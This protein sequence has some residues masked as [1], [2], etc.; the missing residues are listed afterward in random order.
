MKV[1]KTEDLNW[2]LMGQYNVVS[3]MQ[4]NFRLVGRFFQSTGPAETEVPRLDLHF[5][6]SCEAF[7]Q[8]QGGD[9]EVSPG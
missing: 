7:S 5:S 2:R 8:P 3:K 4:F 9:T 6:R 1:E